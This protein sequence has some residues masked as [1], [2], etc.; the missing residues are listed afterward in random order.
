MAVFVLGTH[1]RDMTIH[2]LPKPVHECSHQLSL[3]E[4]QMD[5]RH[6]LV[7]GWLAQWDT[8]PQ[9]LLSET[10]NKLQGRT[11]NWMSSQTTVLSEGRGPAEAACRMVA[12]VELSQ[13]N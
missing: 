9:I 12:S 8:A 13:E 11:T 4:P 6:P 7:G 3:R 10:E 1:S 5:P 2:A